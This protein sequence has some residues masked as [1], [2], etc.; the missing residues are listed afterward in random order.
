MTTGRINQIASESTGMIATCS[1]PL[2]ERCRETT[3]WP[4][5]DGKCGS[6]VI[7]AS[8]QSSRSGPNRYTFHRTFFRLPTHCSSRERG[9]CET[10][11]ISVLGNALAPI[12]STQNATRFG[13]VQSA[14]RLLI[15]DPFHAG[16]TCLSVGT[17]RQNH[18][19]PRGPLI[20]FNIFCRV[21]VSPHI[22]SLG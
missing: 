7:F 1:F 9:L 13:H 4:P 3:L 14:T 20:A 18:T 12:P 19:R 16:K 17:D 8:I 11:R 5:E 15:G 2:I 10:C 6:P 22:Y 21:N